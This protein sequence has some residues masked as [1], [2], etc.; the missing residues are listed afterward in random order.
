MSID[1]DLLDTGTP[2]IDVVSSPTMRRCFDV[3]E[4]AYVKDGALVRLES[5]IVMHST[6]VSVTV[7]VHPS[8]ARLSGNN[9]PRA[10]LAAAAG[11]VVSKA[12]TIHSKQAIVGCNGPTVLTFAENGWVDEASEP[13]FIVDRLLNAKLMIALRLQELGYVLPPTNLIHQPVLRVIIGF[14]VAPECG[15]SLKDGRWARLIEVHEGRHVGRVS[16]VYYNVRSAITDHPSKG[17]VAMI[18]DVGVGVTVPY[19]EEPCLTRG[20]ELSLLQ[21]LGLVFTGAPE[22]ESLLETIGLELF[23]LRKG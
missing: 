7:A 8:G 4:A 19:D 15:K 18:L 20:N 6:S 1:R 3:K 13:G 5:S 10:G 12:N 16:D 23:F 2:V 14:D 17:R 11:E 22:L 9:S 21:R